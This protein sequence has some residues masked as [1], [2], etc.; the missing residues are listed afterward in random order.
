MN[1]YP[2]FYPRIA[3]VAP[4]PGRRQAMIWNNA[5]VVLIGPLGTNFG[6]TLI[7]MY[8]FSFKEMH[9][10]MSG[11]W[12]SF[13]PG[14]DELNGGLVQPPLKLGRGWVITSHVNQW[15][16]LIVHTIISIKTC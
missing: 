5:G 11:K 7:K 3:L 16:W 12:R 2:S 13:C 9:L 1:G 10:K 6:D 15:I 8:T 4:S 14:E